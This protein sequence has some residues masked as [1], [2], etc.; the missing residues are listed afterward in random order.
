[1]NNNNNNNN[2]NN[3][4]A[5][6]FK[7]L[8]NEIQREIVSRLEVNELEE[9]LQ[10]NRHVRHQAAFYFFQSTS[11]MVIG[12]ERLQAFRNVL[13]DPFNLYTRITTLVISD[14]PDFG[15]L[16]GEQAANFLTE[17]LD[18]SPFL[19]V[20]DFVDV[21]DM[22]ILANGLRQRIQR[23]AI[24]VLQRFTRITASTTEEEERQRRVVRQEQRAML[25]LNLVFRE[26]IGRLDIN[27][28]FV[29]DLNG[30]PF[31]NNLYGFLQ[32][33]PRLSVLH[34]HFSVNLVLTEILLACPELTVLRFMRDILRG[35]RAQIS[36]YPAN[37]TREFNYNLRRRMFH[38]ERLTVQG[39]SITAAFCDFINIYLQN[40]VELTILHDV[41]RG[42]AFA[43]A[44]NVFITNP[45]LIRVLRF[46]NV[47]WNILAVYPRIDEYF[48]ILT[49]LRVDNCQGVAEHNLGGL[50][51]AR[52]SLD[53]SPF[54]EEENQDLI[55]VAVHLRVRNR[56]LYFLH[57]R[58]E[59]AFLPQPTPVIE[60]VPFEDII[61]RASDINTLE[62]YTGDNGWSH[63]INLGLDFF[64]NPLFE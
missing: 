38:L 43:D 59:D 40:L 60:G 62:L 2:N 30:E 12:L 31:N 6:H 55:Q 33:F 47:G 24:G 8:P 9:L 23:G 46:Y 32:Q 56:R 54:L 1:M 16:T 35:L 10:V 45:S 63:A 52:F 37:R 41:F 34:L 36:I 58:G 53:V 42:R 50:T 22:A 57:R 14:I 17:I 61:I 5:F 64:P 49:V 25:R 39:D 7:R 44:F 11:V 19:R 29:Q 15:N 13:Q 27:Q 26:S 3:D 28:L 4:L 21:N 20:L 18:R 48:P 51:L